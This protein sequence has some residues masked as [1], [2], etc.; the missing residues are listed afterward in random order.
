MPQSS[1]TMLGFR[2]ICGESPHHL[3]ADPGVAMQDVSLENMLLNVN[4]S[5]VALHQI[6]L[7][8]KI[9]LNRWLGTEWMFII[10]SY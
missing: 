1:I 7:A 5:D 4:P 6:L 9:R 8:S 10:Y 3:G 2:C